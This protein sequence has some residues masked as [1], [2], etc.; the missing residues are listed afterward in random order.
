MTT[1]EGNYCRNIF[2]KL[3]DLYK[4]NISVDILNHKGGHYFSYVFTFSMYCFES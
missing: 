3:W 4:C 1:P 2:H